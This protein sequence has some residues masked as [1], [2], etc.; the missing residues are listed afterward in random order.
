MSLEKRT[1]TE[2]IVEKRTITE[3][4]FKG[5]NVPEKSYM[6]L[7]DLK[8]YRKSSLIKMFKENGIPLP[9]Y[10]KSKKNLL[11]MAQHFVITEKIAPAVEAEEPISPLL[12]KD[13]QGRID[14]LTWFSPSSDDLKRF[15]GS[16]QT[17]RMISWLC[18][19]KNLREEEVIKCSDDQLLVN[20]Y[21]AL[22]AAN[23]MGAAFRAKLNELFV[24]DRIEQGKMEAMQKKGR[25]ASLIIED[26]GLLIYP[27]LHQQVPQWPFSDIKHGF[28][29][30]QIGNHVK[31]GGTGMKE[32]RK[33]ATIKKRFR[34]HR[35][36]HCKFILNALFKF[37]NQ[38][39]ADIFETV[40]KMILREYHIGSDERM[41]QYECPG[42]DSAEVVVKMV[43]EQFEKMKLLR[44]DQVWRKL[45]E[46][47]IEFYNH[48]SSE[49]SLPSF[50]AKMSQVK[51]P[52]SEM[53]PISDYNEK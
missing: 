51:S 27:T 46:E 21:I 2:I 49:A 15:L 29:V 52:K 13:S 53:N 8:L 34:G 24:I 23:S 10:S 45:S 47:E 33:Y 48:L 36:T 41:E 43:S 18:K 31:I 32:Y 1:L 7:K 25:K 20:P 50:W 30:F 9:S 5:R 39:A 35:N 12:V 4:F 26:E 40:S 3:I 11:I 19:E 14:I 16:G 22:L 42:Q 38:E 44:K 37:D 28:Y 17:Q 6:L